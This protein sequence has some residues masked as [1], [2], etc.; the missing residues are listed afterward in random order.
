MSE[1]IDRNMDKKS[2]FAIG[3]GHL[4]GNKGVLALLKRRNISLEGIK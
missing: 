1:R 3:A 2:F 4:A